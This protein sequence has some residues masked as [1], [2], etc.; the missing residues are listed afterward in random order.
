MR[1]RLKIVPDATPNADGRWI[2]VSTESD[3]PSYCTSWRAVDHFFTKDIP[4]DEHLVQYE[5]A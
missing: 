4:A 5:A 2:A 3:Y 1:Y